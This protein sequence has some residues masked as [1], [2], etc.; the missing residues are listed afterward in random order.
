M[1]KSGAQDLLSLFNEKTLNA[2]PTHRIAGAVVS[3]WWW[4]QEDRP[5][6]LLDVGS[7]LVTLMLL[8]SRCC[9]IASLVLSI[10]L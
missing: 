7:L 4:T 9:F 1:L 3:W 6:K 5:I 8:R 2:P 10:V